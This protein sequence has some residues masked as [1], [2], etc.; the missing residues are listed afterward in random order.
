VSQA[1]LDS[2]QAGLLTPTW[3]FSFQIIEK[4]RF[5]VVPN[6]LYDI[7]HRVLN[8]GLTKFLVI[9]TTSYSESLNI[10]GDRIYLELDAFVYLPILAD[11][12]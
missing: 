9:D 12:K 3:H 8:C 5:I 2:P 6:F 7:E 11:A 4:T 10:L 1:K